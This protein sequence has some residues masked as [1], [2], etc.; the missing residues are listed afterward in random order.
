M[1]GVVVFSRAS[2]FDSIRALLE[3]RELLSIY[4]AVFV[5]LVVVTS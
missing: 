2:A 3:Q 5:W 4:N 1:K